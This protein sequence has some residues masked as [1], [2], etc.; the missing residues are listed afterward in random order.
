VPRHA[1]RGESAAQ[2]LP[3]AAAAAA[4][5]GARTPAAEATPGSRA[6]SFSA[7]SL[8]ATPQQAAYAGAAST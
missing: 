4:A 7:V 6:A 8:A 5:V 2:A 3:S 1:T